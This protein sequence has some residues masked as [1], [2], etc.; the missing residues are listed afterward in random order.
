MSATETAVAVE[1]ELSPR[2]S[3][4]RYEVNE[5]DEEVERGLSQ[6]ELSQ[7]YSRNHDEIIDRP[8]AIEPVAQELKP[9][10]RGRDAWS[11]LLGAFAFDALFW[12]N[13]CCSTTSQISL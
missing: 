10:D 4:S 8:E 1:Y 5:R 9:V 3:R 11:T 7:L 2:H 12:G 13:F 6:I